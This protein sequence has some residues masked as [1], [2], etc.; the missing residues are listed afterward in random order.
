MQIK[1][2]R[3]FIEDWEKVLNKITARGRYRCLGNGDKRLEN[4]REGDSISGPGF[5]EALHKSRDCGLRAITI[6]IGISHIA[7]DK[8][9][10]HILKMRKL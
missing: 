2:L 10:T 7:C 9:I 8:F 1:T 4:R 3:E 6:K 5:V